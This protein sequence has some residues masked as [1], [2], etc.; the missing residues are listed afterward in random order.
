MLIADIDSVTAAGE[1]AAIDN[2]A[3]GAWVVEPGATVMLDI[4]V[5]EC[6]DAVINTTACG[7]A[8]AP[9]SAPDPF[10]SDQSY[11]GYDVDY[12][13]EPVPSCQG[14]AAPAANAS[15]C[16]GLSADAQVCLLH[17][18][19]L[20]LALI[21]WSDARTCNWLSLRPF[22]TRS[23][24]WPTASPHNSARYAP[25]MHKSLCWNLQVI[26]VVVD[27][28]WLQLQLY[29]QPALASAFLTSRAPLMS[30]YHTLETFLTPERLS[31]WLSV[32]TQTEL[33]A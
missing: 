10:Y 2:E 13:W 16:S 18:P 4:S 14:A 20:A 32:R 26:V 1:P 6:T 25:K 28:A 3:D 29:S 21:A 15:A 24:G 9:V 23:T 19:V 7:D 33:S 11:S 8:D 31:T 5:K 30:L 17:A 22:D 12:Y 27:K